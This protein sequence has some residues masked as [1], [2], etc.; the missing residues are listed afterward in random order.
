LINWFRKNIHKDYKDKL[1]NAFPKHLEQD[2]DIV[3]KAIPFSNNNIKLADG[4]FHKV[5]N[6]IF[7]NSQL[8]NL[9]KEQLT[10]PYRVYFNEPEEKEEKTL[11]NKQQAILNC[12]YLR[13]HNGFVRQKRLKKLKDISDFWTT[14]FVF[15]LLGEYVIEILEVLDKQIN[16]TILDNFIQFKLDNPKYFEQTES[17]MISYWNEYYRRDNPKLNR[18]VG[19]LIFDKVKIKIKGLDIDEITEIAIDKNERLLIKPKNTRFTLIYRTAT[20]VHWDEKLL[21]LYSPKPR[22]WT[23]LNWYQHIIN[24]AEVECNTKL[25]LT[26]RTVWTNITN[27]LKKQIIENKKANAQHR[28]GKSRADGSN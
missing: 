13:H 3:L 5:D 21:S 17:R 15:Q 4:N 23:Y 25:M 7:D 27:E 20:E 8:V 9:D 11:T 26:T 10:I 19:R 18:Y 14:P 1:K 28:F 16:N 22:E 12:I 24:V 6:L 2:L